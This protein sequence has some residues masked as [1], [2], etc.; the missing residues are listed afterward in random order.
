MS[1][2]NSMCRCEETVARAAYS[3][4]I[5]W[6]SEF[7]L[8]NANSDAC[9]TAVETRA[10]VHGSYVCINWLCRLS[11]AFPARLHSTCKSKESFGL[12]HSYV[13]D[14]CAAELVGEHLNLSTRRGDVMRSYPEL[15]SACSVPLVTREMEQH[16]SDVMCALSETNQSHYRSTNRSKNPLMS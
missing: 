7:K 8:R 14:Q 5:E 15:T 9:K 3:P 2:Y 16:L 12:L 10:A 4:S 1:E 13:L 6:I 11:P